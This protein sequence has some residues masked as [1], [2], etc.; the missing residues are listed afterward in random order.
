M[1]DIDT[2]FVSRFKREISWLQV[3][4]SDAALP[5]SMPLLPSRRRNILRYC[6]NLCKNF[7]QK[8]NNIGLPIIE[9]P[10]AAKDISDG[11]IV[12]IDFDTGKIVNVTKNKEYTG[13]P[14]LNL[15]RK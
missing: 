7:L 8:C 12:S 15:C 2:E 13:V 9:C 10:E 14:S 5:E 1:E 4:T 6:R 11:D 3:K